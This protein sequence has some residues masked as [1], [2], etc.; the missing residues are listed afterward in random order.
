MRSPSSA[1]SSVESWPFRCESHHPG[2]CGGAENRDAVAE[3]GQRVAGAGA[4]S[5]VGGARAEDAGFRSMRAARSEFDD[6]AALRGMDM[7]AAFVAMS[8]SK[9]MAESR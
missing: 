1:W 3:A 9:V 7:R 2:V 5:D 4:A 8:V 6:V